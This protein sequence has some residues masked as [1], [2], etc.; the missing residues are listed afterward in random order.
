MGGDATARAPYDAAGSPPPE[1]GPAA[2]GETANLVLQHVGTVL[3]FALAWV[4]IVRLFRQRQRASVTF[5]WLLA[6]VLVPY[7]GVPLFL[8]FGDRKLRRH[9]DRSGP[10]R[11]PE[12]PAEEPASSTERLLGTEALPP[13]RPGNRV[14]ILT[15]G[16]EAFRA[17]IEL[18]DGARET[19]DVT[20]FLIGRDEVG[21]EAVERLAARARE[22]LRVRLILDAVG[23]L[24]SRGA[25]LRPLRAAGAEIAIFLPVLPLRRRWST[26]LRNHRKLLVADGRRAWTGGRNLASEYL[27]PARREDR[28][29][30]ASVALEG[31]AVGDLVQV[32]END[33]SLATGRPA[34]DCPARTPPVLERPDAARVQVVVSGPDVPSDPMADALTAAVFAARRRVWVVTPYFVPDESLQRALLIQARSGCDVCLILPARS[35][36]R[37]ADLVRTRFLDQLREHGA[38][39]L[40]VPD[41]MVHAKALLFDDDLA[42]LGSANLDLR[43]LYLNFEAA[44]SLTSP[45]EIR[46]V[47]AWLARLA[48]RARPYEPPPSSLARSWAEAVGTLVAPL[49]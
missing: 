49:L 12:G 28:W 6:M 30:D 2:M 33:W 44:L 23:G 7:V 41:R 20:T 43:S 9:L 37:L 47:E 22:G 10:P 5:G 27:G 13:P 18:V 42:F 29:I 11:W 48:A 45:R 3:G 16:V 25:F 38:R 17:W 31:P 1:A 34:P 26:N 8:L 21:R 35:N 46:A 40:C 4:L 24:G 19:I 39:I 15:D 14:E 32:F 36:H